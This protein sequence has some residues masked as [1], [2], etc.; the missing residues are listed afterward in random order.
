MKRVIDRARSWLDAPMRLLFG[1]DVFISYSRHDAA[2]Y[3]AALARQLSETHSCYLDQHAAPRGDKLP[4]QLQRDLR[5]A[6][7]L[8][9]V[10]S[11]GARNSVYVAAEIEEFVPSGRPVLP[12]EIGTNDDSLGHS[13]AWRHLTGVF[14][15]AEHA[16][17]FSSAEPSEAVIS[18][19]KN[20]LTFT[21]QQTRLRTATF[22]AVALLLASFADV[23][24][25]QYF[26]L[27]AMDTAATAQ[28]NSERA[29]RVATEAENRRLRAES[30]A[31]RAQH[32]ATEAESLASQARLA[33]NAARSNAAVQQRL[34]DSRRLSGLATMQV[35]THPD[36]GILLAAHA[37]QEYPSPFGE[38]ALLQSL[39]RYTG[40]LRVRRVA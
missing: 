27:K 32:A 10:V 40:L 14:R 5:R 7:A 19:L 11:Q 37:Y 21:R 4:R 29:N 33:E 23:G 1:R 20:S 30:D 2:R 31:Q 12:I 6:S 35:E 17:A 9:L 3:A 24:L 18:W 28:A 34:A 16:D 38:S 15:Q 25:G 13:A 8:V 36:L 26:T 39:T 22:T